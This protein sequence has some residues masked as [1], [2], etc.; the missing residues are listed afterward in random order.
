MEEYVF[1]LIRLGIAS[2]LWLL[3]RCSPVAVQNLSPDDAVEFFIWHLPL[4]GPSA[5]MEMVICEQGG[6]ALEGGHPG[7]PRWDPRCP[8][9]PMDWV[10]LPPASVSVS[11]CASNTTG[12]QS[13]GA[14]EPF[15]SNVVC[16]SLYS[17]CYCAQNFCSHFQLNRSP[18]RQVGIWDWELGSLIEPALR[19]KLPMVCLHITSC[20]ESGIVGTPFTLTVLLW[21]DH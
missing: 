13:R 11:V 19:R 1:I 12:A 10:L 8:S 14:P 6:R 5:F 21:W 9:T 16:K 20:F 2:G 7:D 15:A 18:C 4:S 17:E 3:T